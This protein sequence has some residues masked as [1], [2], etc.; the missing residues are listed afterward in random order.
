MGKP[1]ELLQKVVSYCEDPLNAFEG[2]GTELLQ[3]IKTCLNAS[4]KPKERV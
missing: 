4:K 2:I 1:E 3:E